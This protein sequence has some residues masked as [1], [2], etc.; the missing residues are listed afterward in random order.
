MT[1]D[2]FGELLEA[3]GT[4]ELT[5]NG[6]GRE[7]G[8]RAGSGEEKVTEN[9]LLSLRADG[10]AAARACCDIFTRWPAVGAAARLGIALAIALDSLSGER[11]RG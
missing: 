8:H 5:A 1:G 9:I 4:E 10:R 3:L 6:L 7:E 2:R 11:R